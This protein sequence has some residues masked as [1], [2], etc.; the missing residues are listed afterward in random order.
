[1]S[2]WLVFQRLIG[3]LRAS[4][5]YSADSQELLD[6]LNQ[7]F[8]YRGFR[9]RFIF[10]QLDEGEKLILRFSAVDSDAALFE[11]GQGLELIKEFV[12]LQFTLYNP[13]ATRYFNFQQEQLQLINST[14][15]K[16][17]LINTL[18]REECI[19]YYLIG[20][21]NY[22]SLHFLKIIT[23]RPVEAEELRL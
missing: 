7:F 18:F 15:K 9:S 6:Y 19:N 3:N 1:M 8:V 14:S 4:P 22:E 16:I 11:N 17:D 12:F 2:L 13:R 21:K 20:N 10:E 5:I 23:I